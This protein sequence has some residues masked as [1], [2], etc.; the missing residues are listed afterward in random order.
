MP[1]VLPPH[2]DRTHVIRLLRGAGIQT[3]VHYPAVHQLSFYRERFPGVGLE[4][5]EEYGE[6]ELTLPLHPRLNETHVETVA[7]VL[8]EAVHCDQYA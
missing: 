3:T 5:S 4:I 8:G 6:R 1:V 7:R 2:V